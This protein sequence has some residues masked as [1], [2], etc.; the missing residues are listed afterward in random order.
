MVVRRYFCPRCDE[1]ADID[2]ACIFRDYTWMRID[3]PYF[4]CYRCRTIYYDKRRIWRIVTH[5]RSN[6]KGA[7]RIPFKS[8]YGDAKR[9]LDGVMK[10]AAENRGY[11]FV[12]FKCRPE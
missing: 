3:L 1:E 10:S 4:S 12:R 9:M 11:T 8:I 5:L 7:R 6:N 2:I